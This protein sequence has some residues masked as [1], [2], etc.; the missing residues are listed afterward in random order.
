MILQLKFRSRV[1]SGV[2]V[3]DGKQVLTC[4]KDSGWLGVG[5]YSGL[6]DPA[7][8]TVDQNTAEFIIEDTGLSAG[9]LIS[10]GVTALDEPR[11]W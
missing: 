1:S 3:S 9:C 5:W 4:N 11:E 7:V 6:L 8:D 2:S 10:F